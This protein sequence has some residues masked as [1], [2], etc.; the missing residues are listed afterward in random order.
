MR[1]GRMHEG[2]DIGAPTGAPIHAAASGKVIYAGWL[3][4]YG[5]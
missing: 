4:G 3:S 1:W 5:N 2:I